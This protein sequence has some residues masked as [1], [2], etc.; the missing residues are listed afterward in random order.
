MKRKAILAPPTY[1]KLAELFASP[2]EPT[3][4]AAVAHQ[5]GCMR[6]AIDEIAAGRDPQPSDWRLCSDAANL[7]ETLTEMGECQDPDGL[8]HDAIAALAEA[9]KRHLRGQPIRLDGPGLVAVRGLIEDYAAVL[10][11]L[12]HRTMI[13]CHR[14]TEGRI[15]AILAGKRRPHD[16]EIVDV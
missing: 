10:A 8:L 7:M 5:T 11:V 1:S 14:Q 12:P 16:V 6:K 15:R 9:G 3:P 2:T 4:H 13:R